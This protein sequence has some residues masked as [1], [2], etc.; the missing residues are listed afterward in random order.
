MRQKEIGMNKVKATH[1]ASV[2]L[3]SL[4]ALGVQQVA[5]AEPMDDHSA[6]MGDHA[7]AMDD[8]AGAMDDH[9]GAMDDHHG[10]MHDRSAMGGRHAMHDRYAMGS[11]HGAMHG[12]Y[13]RGGHYG[14]Y[15][16]GG[17][18]GYGARYGRYARGGYYGP[19]YGRYAVGG[20]FAA[21]A[22]PPQGYDYV[23]SYTGTYAS[24]QPNYA[25]GQGLGFFG[26]QPVYVLPNGM[27]TSSL[28]DYYSYR[29]PSYGYGGGLG[30][31]GGP[32]EGVASAA[33]AT[34]DAA[35]LGIFGPTNAGYTPPPPPAAQHMEQAPGMG[36]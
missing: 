30:P 17:Y 18:H 2:A 11:R 4:L 34:L 25:G 21:Q 24:P 16:M 32:V 12:R 3:V 20:G 23:G 28:S 6:A 31:V 22:I 8:H 19:R 13:A 10:A 29:G 5:Q 14:R 9:A 36:Y 27:L 26:S 15:A 7:G 1:L 33:G 35:T